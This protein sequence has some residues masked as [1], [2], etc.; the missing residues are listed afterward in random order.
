MAKPLSQR[1]RLHACRAR[2]LAARRRRR[3][4]RRP[5]LRNRKGRGAC[6]WST[7]SD[8]PPRTMSPT[9]SPRRRSPAPT[10]LPPRRHGRPACLPT[11]PHRIADVATIDGVT[12][13]DDSGATNPHAAAASLAAYQCVVWIAGGLAKGASFDE[14]VRVAASR[15]VV[16]CCSAR[17]GAIVDALATTRAGCARHRSRAPRLAMCPSRRHARWQHRASLA[18]P[19]DTVLLAPA[20]R[21]W[22]CSRTTPSEETSS[23]RLYNGRAPR[24]R[25]SVTAIPGN[26]TGVLRG[27]HRRHVRLLDDRR[28]RLPG[29]RLHGDAEHPRLLVWSASFVWSWEMTGRVHRGAEAACTQ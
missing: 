8:L 22:T 19:G 24:R 15:F 6:Q 21:P 13:V 23:R 16:P 4:T 28:R 25:S 27:F 10:A 11:G 20:A 29:A 17:I 9:R 2:P 1:R 18:H 12:Y 7:T 3:R 26:R 14:L 5:C